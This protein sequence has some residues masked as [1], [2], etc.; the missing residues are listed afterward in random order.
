MSSAQSVKK[1][2]SIKRAFAGEFAAQRDVSR[3]IAAYAEVMDQS[4]K[5][6]S[7]VER[8]EFNQGLGIVVVAGL[9]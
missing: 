5:E 9:I 3:R 1:W 6:N 7:A 8:P 2:A 4:L